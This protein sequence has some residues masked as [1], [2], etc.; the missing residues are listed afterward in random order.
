MSTTR[1]PTLRPAAAADAR[2]GAAMHAA[3]WREAY[4]P[5]ADPDRLAERLADTDRWV[6]AWTRQLEVGPPR[7]LAEDDG[8]LVGFAVVGPSRDDDHATPRELYAIYTRAAYWG[9]GLGQ[10]L[11][12]AVRPDDPCSLWVLEDNDRARGFYA[13]NGFVADGARELYDDLGAWEIRM[14]RS[15]A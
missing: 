1:T 12:D 4:G 7:V 15:P 10:R 6:A 3:C 5:Y 14:V 2:A 13:R 8:G 9:T 11:W